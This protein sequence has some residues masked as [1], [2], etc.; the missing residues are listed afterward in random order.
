MSLSAD[1][2]SVVAVD[3]RAT[4]QFASDSRRG[5]SRRCLPSIRENQATSSAVCLFSPKTA[6]NLSGSPFWSVAASM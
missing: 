1:A 6:E 3:L 2:F 4:V 5:P